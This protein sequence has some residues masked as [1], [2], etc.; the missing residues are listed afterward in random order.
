MIVELKLLCGTTP[1]SYVHIYKPL[2]NNKINKIQQQQ[3][4]NNRSIISL[5]PSS[6]FDVIAFKPIAILLF[7][8][9]PTRCTIR[10]ERNVLFNDAL[11]TFYFMVIIMA[12]DMVKD[13]SD[14]ERGNLL[15]P[16]FGLLSL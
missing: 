8:S 2:K 16:Q 6:V 5:I 13:H 14:S 3:N 11:N 12:S 9:I 10:K 7:L 4:S 1:W 15:P